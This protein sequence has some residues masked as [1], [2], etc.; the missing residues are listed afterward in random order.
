MRTIR[1]C[2]R[3]NIEIQRNRG[4]LLKYTAYCDR[5]NNNDTVNKNNIVT[6]IPNEWGAYKI[7]E[8]DCV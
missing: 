6:W 3:T 8:Y 4:E 7:Y 2:T 5:A 1:K